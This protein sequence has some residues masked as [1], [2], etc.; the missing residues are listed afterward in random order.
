MQQQT[1]N[2]ANFRILP[3]FLSHYGRPVH[4]IIAAYSDMYHTF[5]YVRMANII[6][7][8]ACFNDA[9]P[10]TIMI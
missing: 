7:L 4:K 1:K 5:A 10:T 3:Y 8:S 9:M 6:L 2:N